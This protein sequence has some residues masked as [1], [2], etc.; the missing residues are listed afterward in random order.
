[1]SVGRIPAA[2]RYL[3]LPRLVATGLAGWGGLAWLVTRV[4]PQDPRAKLFFVLALA[5]GL[6]ATAC[7]I[8]YGITFVLWP[9]A[10]RRALRAF[11]E[12]QGLLWSGFLATLVLLRLSGEL[13]AVTAAVAAAFFLAAQ[14][15]CFGRTT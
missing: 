7:L 9:A 15:S 2:A 5:A 13:S 3:W 6:Y 14:Y 11:G 12:R 4:G 10:P 1:M 8:A